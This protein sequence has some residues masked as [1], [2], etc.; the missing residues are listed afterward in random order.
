MDFNSKYRIITTYS[1]SILLMFLFLTEA[2]FKIT[3]YLTSHKILL[4]QVTKGF[5]LIN[6]LIYMFLK[7]TKALKGVFLFFVCFIIG[8][9]SLKNGF[10]TNVMVAFFKQIFLLIMLLFFFHCKIRR[11]QKKNF[12]DFFEYLILFN[13]II[14]IVGFLFDLKIFKSY[15]GERFG[16]NG[17]FITSGTGSYVYC[18]TLIFLLKKYNDKVLKNIRNLIIVFSMFLV[19][20][21]VSYL[22][23]FFFFFVYLWGYT[24]LN[25]IYLLSFFSALGV[26]TLYMFFFKY[27]LF[28]KIRLE[29]GFVSSLMSYRDELLL[30][31]TLPSIKK[32]W[33]F[34]NYL[35]GGI[36]V[37]STRSQIELVDVFYSSGIIGGLLYYYLF[38]K[39]FLIFNV[40]IYINFILIITFIIIL[41]AGNFFSYPSLAIYVVIL[42][43]HLNSYEQNKHT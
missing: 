15:S 40:N 10:N 6:V 31:D 34:F 14:I 29:D 7:K 4:L 13:S 38:F 9:C 19:G 41:L 36:D 27:S 35:F 37:L 16:Y 23:L 11:N 33:K 43:E 39:L 17:F 2:Y 8:Q 28:N 26:L 22:F 30:N 21:K 12:F 3:L 1:F 20:T 24:N 25:K 32:N 5:I 42:R 18:I